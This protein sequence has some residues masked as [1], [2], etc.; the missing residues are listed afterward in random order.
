MAL[1]DAELAY[2]AARGATM[3][4]DTPLISPYAVNPLVGEVKQLWL[5]VAELSNREL[6]RTA[7]HG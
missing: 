3:S 7:S 6:Q 5:I 4:S 1:S 2:W